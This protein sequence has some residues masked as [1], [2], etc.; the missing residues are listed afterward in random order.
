MSVDVKQ[1][2]IENKEKVSYYIKKMNEL[3]QKDKELKLQILMHNFQKEEKYRKE[4]DEKNDREKKHIERMNRF[5]IEQQKKKEESKEKKCNKDKIEKETLK[6]RQKSVSCYKKYD[7]KKIDEFIFKNEKFR[8]DNTNNKDPY[9]SRLKDEINKD[10]NKKKNMEKTRSSIINKEDDKN[11]IQQYQNLIDG[12]NINSMSSNDNQDFYHNASL[13]TPMNFINIMENKKSIKDSVSKNNTSININNNKNNDLVINES[14]NAPSGSEEEFNSEAQFLPDNINKINME[15]YKTINRNDNNNHNHHDKY[16]NSDNH[17]DNIY[18]ERRMSDSSNY[19]VS[20]KKNLLTS[21]NAEKEVKKKSK[22]KNLKNSKTKNKVKSKNKLNSNNIINIKKNKSNKLKKSKIPIITDKSKYKFSQV[23]KIAKSKQK[24]PL[25]T[26]TESNN[27]SAKA[28]KPK[29]PIS[30]SSKI[31]KKSEKI[32]L[33][34][35]EQL[36]IKKD[37]I[38]DDINKKKIKKDTKSSKSVSKLINNNKSII[39]NSIKIA[40]KKKCHNTN[41]NFIRL[42]KDNER[43]KEFLGYNFN[44][45]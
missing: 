25:N 41:S 15:Q 31:N 1:I 11:S 37:S 40:N 12:Q 38:T 28:V 16:N 2:I 39:N 5:T 19:I 27:I 17:D 22:V 24:K 10:L 44:T 35:T 20:S 14:K 4:K 42:I 34:T 9:Y 45:R 13:E 33:K 36:S 26:N 29:I 32:H 43:E 8:D 30:N 7:D 21:N 6:E 18:K 23:N 3:E